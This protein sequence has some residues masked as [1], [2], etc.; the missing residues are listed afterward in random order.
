MAE[1]PI[2]FSAPMVQALL[3]GRKTQTRRIISGVPMF[4]AEYDKEWRPNVLPPSGS[5]PHEWSWW[6]GPAHGPSLYHK[7]RLPY[8]PGDR[9][10]VREAFRFDAEWDGCKP[11]V[12]DRADAILYD[13]DAAQMKGL[14]GDPFKP[15]RLRPSIHM[16]RWASR[17][18]LAVTEVRVQRLNDI[19]EADAKAE[20]AGY[21]MNDLGFSPISGQ[22]HGC[23]SFRAGFARLWNSIHGP[24]AWDANRWVVAIS[25]TVA[26]GNIDG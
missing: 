8:A 5:L 20:G 6:E 26:K 22:P 12:F 21:E 10:Y 25:F 19:S 4:S 16:P 11:S 9:L 18:T 24:A 23:R 15:G 3:A 2:I 13:A 14:W 1:R 7:A 17:I